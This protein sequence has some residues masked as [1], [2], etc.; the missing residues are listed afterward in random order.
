M[1]DTSNLV[2]RVRERAFRDAG[3]LPSCATDQDVRAA[4]RELGFSLP[5]L[6]SLLYRTVANGGFGPEYTL[7][8]LSGGGRTVI[9]EYETLHRGCPD[10][11]A[12]SGWT[13]VRIPGKPPCSHPVLPGDR[14][15]EE[16]RTDTRSSRI[17]NA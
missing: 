5:P 1:S 14:C 7:L 9:S 3:S 17:G 4:E 8:P 15:P 16:G 12:D 13:P 2:L 11:R 6:L 10:Q